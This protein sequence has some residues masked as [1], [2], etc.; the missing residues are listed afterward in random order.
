MADYYK[1]PPMFQ[2]M[3]SIAQLGEQNCGA[4]YFGEPGM[5]P[6]AQQPGGDLGQFTDN[7]ADSFLQTRQSAA[8]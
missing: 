8:P 5:P 7:S 6:I 3:P 1:R 2:P 4:N